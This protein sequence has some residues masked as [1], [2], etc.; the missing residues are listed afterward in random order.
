MFVIKKMFCRFV[1]FSQIDRSPS[2]CS[3]C[4]K[5][6]LDFTAIIFNQPCDWNQHSEQIVFTEKK[7]QKETDMEKKCLLIFLM[8]SV[9]LSLAKRHPATH[10]ERINSDLHRKIFIQSRLYSCTFV[11]TWSI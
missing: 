2:K 1:T 9:R 10:M 7:I 8:I 11:E 6:D 4:K 5:T 3:A